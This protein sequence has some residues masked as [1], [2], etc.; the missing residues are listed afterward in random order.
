M[1]PYRA[2]RFLAVPFASSSQTI[3]QAWQEGAVNPCLGTPAACNVNPNP[4]YGTQ[5]TYNGNI[6]NG[7]DPNVTQNPS[8]IL[9]DVPTQKW[10][11]YAPPTKGTNI[12]AYSAYFVFVRG[13]HA[14]DL[15]QAVNATPDPTTLR[16]T[17]VSNETGGA[18]S[19]GSL[20]GSSGQYVLIGNPFAAPVN[21]IDAFNSSGTVGIDKTTFTVM[22]PKFNND[23]RDV[24]AYVTYNTVT[25]WTPNVQLS[26]PSTYPPVVQSGQGLMVK[27]SGTGSHEVSFE[28]S[29]KFT[30]LQA[31]VF[32]LRAKSLNPTPVIYTNLMAKAQTKD[33]LCATDGIAAAFGKQFSSSVDSVDIPKLWNTG[34]NISLLR[35]QSHL[36]IEFRDMPTATDTLFYRLYLR[37][38]PHALK[39]FSKNLSGGIASRAW[40]VDNYLHKETE[41]DLSDTT[42]YNFTPNTDTNSY[43]NRFMLVFTPSRADRPGMIDSFISRIKTRIYPNPVIGKTFNLV[44][45]NAKEGDYTVNIFTTGGKLAATRKI[46][47][48]AAT[49][50]YSISVPASLTAGNYIVQIVA[51]DDFITSSITLSIAQ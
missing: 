11:T 16:I 32:G 35:N 33:S 1:P 26:Y 49:D 46:S 22:D 29:N 4:G 48:K 17:G 38:Q 9:W 37:Q 15:S 36:L 5:I 8:L 23:G 39:I 41:I 40:L 20:S 6:A 14:N 12:R 7:F 47:Y 25:G 34:E 45:E 21:V 28:Q 43:R 18:V 50:T 31:N 10:T 3:N 13:S 30:G 42:I 24:G 27:L 44:L 51:G 19:T 2:W